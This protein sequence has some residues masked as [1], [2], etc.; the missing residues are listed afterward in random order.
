MD[1]RGTRM[2][3]FFELKDHHLDVHIFYN[4]VMFALFR[5][6]LGGLCAIGYQ[7]AR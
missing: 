3:P 7:P 2:V 4:R 1:H 6:H 5:H